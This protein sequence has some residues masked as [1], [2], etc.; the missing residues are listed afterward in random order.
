MTAWARRER[1]QFID[2]YAEA[3]R[4]CDG[5]VIGGGQILV[6]EQLFFPLRIQAIIEM[7]RAAGKPVAVFSCGANARQGRIARHILHRMARQAVQI[8]VRDRASAAVLLSLDGKLTV[9]VGPDIGFLAAR[10]YGA[11]SADPNGILGINLMP[12][13][14]VAAFAR[15]LK[16]VTPAEYLTFWK[17]LIGS[18][19]ERGWCV[20]LMSNG[21]TE[22]HRTAHEV[23][24]AFQ[25][26]RRVELAPQPLAPKEL[27]DT[28]H[29]V[30]ALITCRMHAGIVAYSLGKRVVPL[31]WDKK[32]DAVWSEADPTVRPLPLAAIFNGEASFSTILDRASPTAEATDNRKTITERLDR[33]LDELAACFALLR[34]PSATSYG[35]VQ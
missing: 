11:G 10:T 19:L 9:R 30:D 27:V 21:D 4:S 15:D 29:G 8:N 18:A 32:V 16:Q 3:I 7:A 35:G 1:R 2:T 6:D 22:D 13:R 14:I 26:D 12:H 31:V 23:C 5:V 33:S 34:R 20:R 24:S 25:S 28:L 17:D